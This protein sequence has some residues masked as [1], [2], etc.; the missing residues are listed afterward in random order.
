M[1]Y[2]NSLIENLGFDI[3]QN[4]LSEISLYD[5]NKKIFKNI[6]PYSNLKQLQVN[7]ILT[8]EIKTCL[9]R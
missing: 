7:Q 4:K 1:K 3:I 9:E 2:N 5:D 8:N 6:S